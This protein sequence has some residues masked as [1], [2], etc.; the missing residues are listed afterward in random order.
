M[1]NNAAA[2]SSVPPPEHSIV[3][4]RQLVT[5]WDQYEDAEIPILEDGDWER[6]L[7]IR[8]Q[9]EHTVQMTRAVLTLAEDGLRIA[10][11]PLVRFTMECSVMAA[12]LATTPGSGKSAWHHA[13]KEYGVLYEDLLKVDGAPAS[14][15]HLAVIKA[16]L[17]TL[18]QYASEE[19]RVFRNRCEAV[20]SG[21]WIYAYYRLFSKLSHGRLGLNDEYLQQVSHSPE[22]PLGLALKDPESFALWPV[23]IAFQVTM[24]YNALVVWDRIGK[25]HP[26]NAVL[27]ALSEKYEFSMFTNLPQSVV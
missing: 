25:T 16:E 10:T 14:D 6:G 4:L 2:D 27:E 22:A 19:A 5:A 8:V 13:S 7:S 12:W 11:V 3:V 26:R 20:D 1:A 18:Q 17:A 21:V 15:Q 9:V 23:A 24:L